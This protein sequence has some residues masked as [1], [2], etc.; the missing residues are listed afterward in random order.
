MGETIAPSKPVRVAPQKP[1]HYSD[2]E[3]SVNSL[4]S[5]TEFVSAEQT[6]LSGR[7]GEGSSREAGPGQEARSRQAKRET[8]PFPGTHSGDG[9]VQDWEYICI[10]MSGKKTVITNS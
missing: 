5:G 6:V 9:I 2:Q 1:D 7:R 4:C 10:D 8:G 3:V